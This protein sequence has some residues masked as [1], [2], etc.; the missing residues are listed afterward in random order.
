MRPW[1]SA[2]GNVIA[3]LALVVFGAKWISGLSF[4]GGCGCDRYWNIFLWNSVGFQF[5]KT[6]PVVLWYFPDQ[7]SSIV[8][9]LDSIRRSMSGREKSQEAEGSGNHP[10]N[11]SGSNGSSHAHRK[12]KHDDKSRSGHHSKRRRS[13]STSS[14]SHHRHH[15]HSH[16]GKKS[17]ESS[18]KE[19]KRLQDWWDRQQG[20]IVPSSS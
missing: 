17:Y 8:S 7:S 4:K 14:W 10:D 13:C 18:K 1:I 2:P 15:K 16:R 19:R 12:T 3:S 20:K 6:S 11:I 9:Y 5:A